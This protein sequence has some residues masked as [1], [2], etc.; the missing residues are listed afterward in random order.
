[1]TFYDDVNTDERTES[2]ILMISNPWGIELTLN[3][4][5]AIQETQ[6]ED[7][8]AELLGNRV[9]KQLARLEHVLMLQQSMTLPNTEIHQYPVRTKAG[10]S[11]QF[12]RN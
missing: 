6:P 8:E 1:M 3:Y 4:K 7:P 5:S 11:S 9:L 2:R 10:V 12:G